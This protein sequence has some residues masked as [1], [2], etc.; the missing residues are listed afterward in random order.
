MPNEEEVNRKVPSLP[1]LFEIS[2]VPPIHIEIPVTELDD[3]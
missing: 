1:V 3:F 2:A